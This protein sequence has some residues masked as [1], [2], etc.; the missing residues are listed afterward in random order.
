MEYIKLYNL[1]VLAWK[2]RLKIRRY[3]RRKRGS[4]HVGY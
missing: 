1:E 2:D 4:Y 3:I